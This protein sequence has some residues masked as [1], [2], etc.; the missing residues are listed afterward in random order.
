MTAP[1]FNSFYPWCKDKEPPVVHTPF[2]Q[3]IDHTQGKGWQWGMVRPPR[4][5]H[6]SK[7]CLDMNNIMNGMGNF[8]NHTPGM[9]KHYKLEQEIQWS[10]DE[11]IHCQWAPT[12]L[13]KAWMDNE[14]KFLIDVERREKQRAVNH[15]DKWQEENFVR[16]WGYR[17][18]YIKD[19]L[20][21]KVNTH[22]FRADDF[23]KTK[24]SPKFKVM[25][26]GCSFTY[27]IGVRNDETFP[28]LI[29]NHFDAVN[30]NLGI[31]GGS[32]KLALMT[33]EHM[34]K[35]GYIP[36]VVVVNWPNISRGVIPNKSRF[37][38]MLNA[39]YDDVLDVKAFAKVQSNWEGIANSQKYADVMPDSLNPDA[40]D[41]ETFPNHAWGYHPTNR[42]NFG[43]RDL[44]NLVKDTDAFRSKEFENHTEMELLNFNDMRTKLSY[45][46]KAFDIKLYETFFDARA[47][48]LALDLYKTEPDWRSETPVCTG[49]FNIDRGRDGSHWG[50]KT[51][52]LLA[53][54]FIKL[55]GKDK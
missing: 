28:Q 29:S 7:K 20:L 34:F 46:C 12:D 32:C 22:G 19:E 25:S 27:G 13:S 44:I 40:F 50:H 17:N 24:G 53:N 52:E 3:N 8:D 30:W 6:Y 42:A 49:V 1:I 5:E 15:W 26:L 38:N 9:P 33:A 55:I 11:Y 4:L 16:H 37:E 41:G 14:R 2:P 23:A 39:E 45:M 35:I 43:P 51:H 54:H 48:R 10:E 31:G 18:H 21:Y 47:H 36:D